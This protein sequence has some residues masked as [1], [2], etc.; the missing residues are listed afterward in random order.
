MLITSG[1]CWVNRQAGRQ[2]VLTKGT[3]K[4]A[5][6]WKIGSGDT[7]PEFTLHAFVDPKAQQQP[8]LKQPMS[9]CS[10]EDGGKQR[11]DIQVM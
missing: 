2:G 5:H 10:W 4:T 6:A 9:L 1:C 8:L 3:L 11:R 7:Q